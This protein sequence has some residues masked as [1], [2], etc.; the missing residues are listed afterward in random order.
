MMSLYLLRK[1]CNR[2]WV[3]YKQQTD[4]ENIEWIES[5]TTTSGVQQKPLLFFLTSGIS[6]TLSNFNKSSIRI[7]QL[8]SSTLSY[9]G[10]LWAMLKSSPSFAKDF[11]IEIDQIQTWKSP[12]LSLNSAK[13]KALQNKQI[14]YKHKKEAPQR[15]PKNLCL[16]LFIM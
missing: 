6:H 7:R 5:K 12:K 8:T 13:T 9:F 14:I 2:K 3:Q 11:I 16:G 15:R 1:I 10:I 4:C